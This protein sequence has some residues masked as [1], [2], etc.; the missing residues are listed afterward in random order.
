MRTQRSF[1]ITLV[2]CSTVSVSSFTLADQEDV[3]TASAESLLVTSE[4]ILGQPFAYPTEAPPQVTAAIVTLPPG[5]QTGLH[6][7][8]V[9]MF[10]YVLE[11][12]VTVRYEGAGERVY[13]TGDAL[14]EAI[15]TPH[16]GLNTGPVPARILV[17]F[18]GAEGIPNTVNSG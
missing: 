9:P 8:G 17:V 12:E 15:G 14:L 6:H 13:R 18:I 2:L 1:L 7:H 4:T 3:P 11:G 5:T 16:E 10:A